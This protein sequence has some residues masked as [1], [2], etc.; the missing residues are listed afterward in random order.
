MY[1]E[2]HLQ[3]LLLKYKQKHN[4]ENNNQNENNDTNNNNN[5]NNNQNEEISRTVTLPWI[6]VSGPKLRKDYRKAGYKVIFKS[7]AN[8]NTILTSKKQIAV[9][10]KQS[11]R[12]IQT[13]LLMRKIV[14]RRNRM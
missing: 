13:Y 11:T 8:L 5:N 4:I 12:C 6:P 2:K 14:Y 9:I 10:A 3:K 1:N 7:G